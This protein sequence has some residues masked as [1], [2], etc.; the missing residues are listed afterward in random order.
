M[1][2]H[3]EAK[4][5]LSKYDIPLEGIECSSLEQAKEKIKPG[6]PF[7]LKLV[8][9]TEEATHKTE[10]GYVKKVADADE[11]QQAWS[12]MQETARSHGH[13]NIRFILQ[14][15]RTGHEVM[16]GAKRDPIFDFQIIFTPEGGKYA[17]I[18][19]KAVPPSVRVGRITTSEAREMIMEHILSPK[20]TGARGETPV[21]IDSLA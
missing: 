12:R 6:V 7:F 9:S 16:I 17:E 14:Q 15:A 4:K 20:I 1:L 3:L 18:H 2:N 5:L 13:E 8:S 11:L 10:F 19:A 21:D